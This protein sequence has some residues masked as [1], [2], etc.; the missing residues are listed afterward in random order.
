MAGGETSAD[1]TVCGMVHFPRGH[2]LPKNSNAI[3]SKMRESGRL[4]R[5]TMPQFLDLGITHF[6]WVN[7]RESLS[8]TNED[9]V[10]CDGRRIKICQHGGF[11]YFYERSWS[12]AD[13]VYG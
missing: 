1:D 7:P 3:Y 13:I 4:H 2:S 8:L 9:D 6:C 11:V 10:D 12:I 5:V